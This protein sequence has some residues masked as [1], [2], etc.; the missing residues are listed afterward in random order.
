M[1]FST[2]L[3]IRGDASDAKAEV[4]DTSKAVKAL[5]ADVESAGRKSRTAASGTKAIGSAAGATAAQT[6]TLAT[7][8]QN[9]ANTADRMNAANRGAAGSMGN[10]IAQ[11]NDVGIMMAAGQNPLQLALQQGTQISQVIGPMGAAG[12][13]KALGGA[14]LGMLNPISLF[15]IGSIAAGAAL[16]QWLTSAGEE[17]LTFEKQMDA[18]AAS[19]DNYS[20]FAEQARQSTDE[21]E[22]S[23]GSAAASGKRLFETRSI[24][25][26]QKAIEALQAAT[27]AVVEQMGGLSRD[28]LVVSGGWFGDGT[29]MK[30]IDATVFKIKD[31]FSLTTDKA[32]QLVLALE[33]IDNA[34]SLE[35]G[36]SAAATFNELLLDIFGSAEKVPAQLREA[37]LASNE[38]AISAGKIISADE[39]RA[40]ALETALQAQREI[41]A[42]LLQE[43]QINQLIDQFGAQSA[44]V[45]NAKLQQRREAYQLQLAEKDLGAAAA[46]EGMAAFDAANTVRN[47]FSEWA[48]GAADFAAAR[49]K[50]NIEEFNSAQSIL[51]SL[52]EQNAI[53][54]AILRHGEDSAQVSDLRAAAER[55]AFEEI[56]ASTDVSADLKEELRAAFMAGQDLAA[57][58]MAA[59]IAAAAGEAERLA[60]WLGIALSKAIELSATTPAMADE[61]QLMSQNVLPT[62]QDRQRQQ[63]AVLNF[64]R[65][66]TPP[67]RRGGGGGR[68]AAI[69]EAEREREAVT[70]LIAKL[71][72]ELALIRETDPVKKELLRNREALTAATAEEREQIEALIAQREAETLAIEQQQ[73]LWGAVR[74]TAYETFTDLIGAG[75]EYGDVLDNLIDKIVDMG[76]QALL[77]GE[78]P[79]AGIFGGGGG[80]LF[81]DIL[82]SVFPSFNTGRGTGL[83]ASA[84]KGRETLGLP[85][86]EL[87]Q[88][89]AAQMQS[90]DLSLPV[91]PFENQTFGNWLAE[92]TA[93][94]TN[95]SERPA[96]APGR[97]ALDQGPVAPTAGTQSDRQ[98][99]RSDARPGSVNTMHVTIDMTGTQGD[100]S[101]EEKGYRGMQRALEEFN[102]NVLPD[103]VVQISQEPWRRG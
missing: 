4:A 93:R 15:T 89:G 9:A 18:L 48:R 88:L 68:S 66:T 83:E 11:F 61:D 5:G 98:G 53:Q 50:A 95:L 1:S 28:Q 19:I 80:G 71:K 77:L 94:M 90:A 84:V 58:N 34:A 57:L 16:T 2:S 38:L 73:E 59:G 22:S 52:Q 10:L 69:K 92:L 63:R 96:I 75:G 65:L 26:R 36:V 12:A 87:P 51:A 33:A 44:V 91:T 67:R 7:A 72:D 6:N 41:N 13:V 3:L 37:A 46:A 8:Q 17:T 31:T 103:R 56:L 64:D 85:V 24:F 62:A 43:A 30:E 32:G 97:A 101:I 29:I 14:F 54:A 70:D 23:F 42:E 86:P 100:A 74:S 79:L 35:Q 40:R 45:A 102:Q 76:L 82:G 60:S 25:E 49:V 27:S 39:A 21:M 78:G 20:S 99:S 81:G 55:R 47:P